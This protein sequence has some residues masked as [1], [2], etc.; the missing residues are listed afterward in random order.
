MA[1]VGGLIITPFAAGHLELLFDTIVEAFSASALKRQ[2]DVLNNEKQ[3][4]QKPSVFYKKLNLQK[5]N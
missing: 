1:Q 2:Q 3:G 5:Q 4:N